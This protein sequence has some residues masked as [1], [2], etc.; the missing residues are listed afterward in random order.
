MNLFDTVQQ[1]LAALRGNF[2]AG[3]I[4]SLDSLDRA[5]SQVGA[6]QGDVGALTNRLESTSLALDEAKELA[7]NTLSSFED[8]DL[9][10]TISELTLQEYAIQAAG[11]TLGR[12]FD[13]TLLKYLR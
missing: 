10:R 12:I 4:E 6:A 11:A 3:I 13:N 8:I 1:L 2:K 7:T 5:I 9:A